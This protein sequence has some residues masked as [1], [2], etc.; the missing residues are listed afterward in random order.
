MACI[1]VGAVGCSDQWHLRRAIKK[2]PTILT[3]GAE[4]IEHDTMEVEVAA[5]ELTEMLTLA[6]ISGKEKT[7][8]Q[9][10]IIAR[11]QYD[12]INDALSVEVDVPPQYIMVP[13]P[14][15]ITR[16]EPVV[17]T[18]W[19]G[20]LKKFWRTLLLVAIA[21]FLAGMFVRG[22]LPW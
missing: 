3:R 11:L 14:K 22:R 7:I 4:I 2:D 21:A 1:L 6:D 5:R 10:G 15:Y 12:T 13:Y 17:E 9:D 8:E 20:A 16:I 18:S 19:W